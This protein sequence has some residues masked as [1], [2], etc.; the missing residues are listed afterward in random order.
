MLT[1][2]HCLHPVNPDVVRMGTISLLSRDYQEI[3]VEK[4]IKHPGFSASTKAND[5]AILVLS[6]PADISD[7]ETVYPACLDS[8][9]DFPLGNVTV[10]GWGKTEG[11]LNPFNRFILFIQIIRIQIKQ[12]QVSC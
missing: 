3:P 4:V 6:Q 8:R 11:I 1:A 10:T 7:P 12:N 5:V 2:A 9:T